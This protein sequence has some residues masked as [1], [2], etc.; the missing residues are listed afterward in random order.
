[1]GSAAR[2]PNGFLASLAPDDF[3][4]IL[5]HLRTVDLEKDRPLFDLGDVVQHV[6][7]PHNAVVSYIVGFE[8]GDR[9]EVAIV[10]RDSVVGA[11]AALG[12]PVVLT[13]AVVLLAGRASSV[14]AGRLRAAADRSVGLRESLLRHAQS[15]F[16]QAQQMAACNASHAVEARLA[17]WLLRIRDLVGSDH[18]TLTQE[19]MAQLM[20]AR[21]NSVSIVAHTLMQKNCIRYSRGDVEIIDLI[22]LGKVACECYAAMNAQNK[23][24]RL[25]DPVFLQQGFLGQDLL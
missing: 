19:R 6:Y 7:F 1:M 4:A 5:P 21:R 15:V 2:S 12:D 23:R 3:E 14:D 11:S 8:A 18:F 17:R 24:L 16:V 9:V 10:G 20:G 25:P 22:G 13:N